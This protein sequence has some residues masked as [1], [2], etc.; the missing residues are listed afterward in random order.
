MYKLQIN[1]LAY[2]FLRKN[3]MIEAIASEYPIRRMMFA[4]AVIN[5]K[6]NEVLK[7]RGVFENLFDA[8]Y[9]VGQDN[10]LKLYE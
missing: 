7:Y 10:K 9:Q 5:T 1:D 8:F 6:T 3:S 2:Y 4:D